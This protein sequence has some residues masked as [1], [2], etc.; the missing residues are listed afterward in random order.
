MKP[1]HLASTAA[2]LAAA[3]GSAPATIAQER[4]APRGEQPGGGSQ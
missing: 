4:P 2:V 3:V 1:V